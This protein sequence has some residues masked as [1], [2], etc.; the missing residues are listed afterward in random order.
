[1][2]PNVC[3][4]REYLTSI[5]LLQPNLNGNNINN[6][7]TDITKNPGSGR[8]YQQGQQKPLMPSANGEIS[9]NVIKK[10]PQTSLPKI[11]GRLLSYVE[12]NLSANELRGEDEAK[13]EFRKK[14]DA[15]GIQK[16]LEFEK[17]AGRDP[18]EM[19]H[20]NKGYDI[21][22]W[23]KDVNKIERIIE[24]KSTSGEWGASGV[25]LSDSQYEK[26]LEEGDRY[27]LYVVERADRMDATIYCIQN[28]AAQVTNYCFDYG[29][30]KLDKK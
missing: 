22:S 28:P 7:N 23:N 12:N 1:M 19:R 2:K 20:N 13:T 21:K 14:L 4:A 11:Q 8:N 24:V 25:K 3:W 30:K 26:N 10:K 6:L 5:Q 18:D 15:A 9:S 27:W 17:R 16:V 29:W